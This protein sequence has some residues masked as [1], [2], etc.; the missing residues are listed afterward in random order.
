MIDKFVD[1]IG[2]K[3][4]MYYTN[5]DVLTKTKLNELEVYSQLYSPDIICLT[6]V[7]PK[8]SII[9]YCADMYFLKGYVL[10]SSSLSLRGICIFAKPELKVVSL[11]TISVFKEY[12]VYI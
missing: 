4:K 6:E 9:V 8:N 10:V 12:L 3:F 5:C 2:S 7:L 11:D 1:N